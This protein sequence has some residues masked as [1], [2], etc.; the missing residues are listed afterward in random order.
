MSEK[1]SSIERTTCES[2][3]CRRS[4]SLVICTKLVVLNKI[5]ISQKVSLISLVLLRFWAKS[6][7]LI[8]EISHFNPHQYGKFNNVNHLIFIVLFVFFLF[9]DF[10]NVCYDFSYVRKF[11][12]TFLWDSQKLATI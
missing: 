3:S 8:L 9:F 12:D 6:N 11:F 10:F 1:K 7:V 4:D 5:P 2:F